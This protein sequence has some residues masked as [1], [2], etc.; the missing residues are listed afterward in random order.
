MKLLL[1]IAVC[2]GLVVAGPAQSSDIKINQRFTGV[3][4]PTGVD[5]NDDGVF[6]G[7]SSF[8]LVGSPGRATLQSAGEFTPPFRLAKALAISEV[9]SCKKALSRRSTM[10]RCSSWWPLL[11][12]IA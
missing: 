7:A 10:A 8:E 12:T 4:H 2:A 1:I 9:S 6:V 3:A 5:T 11:D